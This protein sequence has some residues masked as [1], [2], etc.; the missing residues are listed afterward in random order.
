MKIV[1]YETKQNSL[2]VEVVILANGESDPEMYKDSQED[3]WDSKT[4]KIVKTTDANQTNHDTY[5]NKTKIEGIQTIANYRNKS[6][7]MIGGKELPVNSW[8]K[9]LM[10]IYEK[11]NKKIINRGKKKK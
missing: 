9:D 8:R 10:V 4:I 11:N 7:E 3:V 6:V 5:H 1:D 2:F